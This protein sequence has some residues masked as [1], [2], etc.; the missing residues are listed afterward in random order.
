MV[1]LMWDSA[2]DNIGVTGYKIYRDGVE[3]GT[4]STTD[5]SDSN[6]T[7]STT[8]TYTIKAY[9]A[10]GNI[11]DSSAELSITTDN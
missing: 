6:L 11:S 10:A 2:T 8:Y 7:P 3:V 1:D 4:A 5:Y 9:D